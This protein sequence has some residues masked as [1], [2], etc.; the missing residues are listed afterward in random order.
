ML[1][2]TERLRL[3]TLSVLEDPKRRLPIAN[4]HMRTRPRDCLGRAKVANCKVFSASSGA[5]KPGMQ[6]WNLVRDP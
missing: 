5:D 6:H 2:S 3:L 4:K 1:H